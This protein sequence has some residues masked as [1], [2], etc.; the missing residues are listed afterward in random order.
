MRSAKYTGDCFSIEIESEI[1]ESPTTGRIKLSFMR[2]DVYFGFYYHSPYR[3]M[4]FSNNH[5]IAYKE[6]EYALQ[7]VSNQFLAHIRRELEKLFPIILAKEREK[8]DK[9]PGGHEE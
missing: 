9:G 4:S 3:S 8:M 7:E 1:T 5:T 2:P 6:K